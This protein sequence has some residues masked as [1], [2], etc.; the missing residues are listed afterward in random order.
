MWFHAAKL[1]L[2]NDTKKRLKKYIPGIYI[3]KFV[4]CY[5]ITIYIK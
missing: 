3:Y 5:D 1:G 4:Y 2:F